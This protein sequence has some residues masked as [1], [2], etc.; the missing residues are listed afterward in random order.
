VELVSTVSMLYMPHP[1]KIK[2]RIKV[3]Y[4]FI[5]LH[6]IFFVTY[7]NAALE[8]IISSKAPPILL[9]TL[10]VRGVPSPRAFENT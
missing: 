8:I 7:P 5:D 6:I 4:R 1:L 9:G 10:S 3:I 2:I